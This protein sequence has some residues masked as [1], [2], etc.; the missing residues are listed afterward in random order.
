MVE[1][2]TDSK[3]IFDQAHSS[4]EFSVRHM[5]ISNVTGRF[6]HIEGYIIGNPDA[7]HLAKAEVSI[8]TESVNTRDAKRDQHLRSEDFFHSEK[9]PELKFVSV[10]VEK[11]SGDSY[12]IFG[13]LTIRGVTRDVKLRGTL[14]GVIKDPYGKTRMGVTVEG[15][16]NRE[17]F[18]LKYNSILETG[19]VMVGNTVK[20]S[21]HAEAVKQE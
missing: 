7:L 5:M 6:D 11:L 19:G 1:Q 4:A 18:G 21:V 20:L 2:S 9:F 10:K 14:E 3:W 16:I 13:K 12:T 8:K 17:E 15:E